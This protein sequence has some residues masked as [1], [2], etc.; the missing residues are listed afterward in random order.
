MF[1]NVNLALAH[2]YT[3]QTFVNILPPIPPPYSK[4]LEITRFSDD[5]WKGVVIQL[6]LKCIACTLGIN[7]AENSLEC[8]LWTLKNSIESPIETHILTRNIYFRQKFLQKYYILH[9]FI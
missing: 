6:L 9:I 3:P 5:N 1:F 8:S 4:F 2:V 7:S